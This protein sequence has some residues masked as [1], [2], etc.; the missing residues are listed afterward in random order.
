MRPRLDRG[1]QMAVAEMPGEPRQ[2]VR[3]ARA[4]YEQ[5]LGPGAHLDDAPV[6]Q[7]EAIA[8][9]QDRRFGKIE[10]E[11]QP[12]LALHG[13]AAAMA[14]VVGEHDAIGGR[15]GPVPARRSELARIKAF[16]PEEEL[17]QPASRIIDPAR[18]AKNQGRG[19]AR[20]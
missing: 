14:I 17:E 19:S 8:L 10:E 2:M 3:I 18:W 11:H 5:R 1:G 13:E 16:R 9:A 7:H 6:L 15:A 12:A 4:N 20:S